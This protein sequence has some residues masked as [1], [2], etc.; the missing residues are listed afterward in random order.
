MRKDVTTCTTGTCPCNTAKVRG[1]A[2]RVSGKTEGCLCTEFGTWGRDTGGWVVG[3]G[4]GREKGKGERHEAIKTATRRQA[5]AGG[6]GGGEWGRTGSSR[7]E[8]GVIKPGTPGA[9]E[10]IVS[11]C[12]PFNEHRR[13]IC[14]VDV[15]MG[16][17]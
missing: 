16:S 15:L 13:L 1:V 8:T 6:V 14:L 3:M 11:P 17:L 5:A 12:S 4:G 7:E 2:C 9:A 10:D